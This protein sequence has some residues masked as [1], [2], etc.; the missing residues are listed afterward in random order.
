MACV[1]C[2]RRRLLS[3]IMLEAAGEWAQNPTGPSLPEITRRKIAEA[4]SKG[5]LSD[6]AIRPTS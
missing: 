1:G 5:E 4:T 2:E 6:D 3:K